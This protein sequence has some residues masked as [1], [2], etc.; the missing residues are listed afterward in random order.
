MA[1][2]EQLE[3]I[4][5]DG[6]DRWNAWRA[7]HPE[8]VTDIAGANLANVYLRAANFAN[9]NL[10]GANLE[11]SDL[12][13]ANLQ[14]TNL[15]DADL[16]GADLRSA[17]LQDA[18]LQGADL[19]AA[20]LTKANLNSA[21]LTSANVSDAHFT[22]A[23]LLG[24][25]FRGA[26]LNK[27][28]FNNAKISKDTLGLGGL[29]HGTRAS[30]VTVDVETIDVA[31]KPEDTL[32]DADAQIS[33]NAHN[34]TVGYASSIVGPA[35]WV[36][37]GLSIPN[38]I[39]EEHRDLIVKLL[40]TVAELEQKLAAIQ[41]EKQLLSDENEELRN[42]INQALPLWK[43]AW[44]EFVLKG[45]GGIGASAGK[46]AVFVAGFIAGTLYNSFSPA[47]LGISV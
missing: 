1:D 11:G 10:Q 6:V 36:L 21:N 45:A 37:K 16:R 34:L 12:Q 46:A 4:T 32:Q 23:D 28:D 14:G 39:N 43:R 30:I 27:T 42:R 35:H 2:D 29:P 8:V 26:T 33:D 9:T 38:D 41:D 7:D 3:I 5:E 31:A 13:S 20:N 22:M 47:G 18:N 40:N 17:N 24:S 25:N 15:Q 44:E 19:Q